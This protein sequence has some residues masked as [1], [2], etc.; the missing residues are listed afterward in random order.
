M[1]N[2]KRR[3]LFKLAGAGSVVAAAGVML[4]VVGQLAS[5]DSDSFAFR[6]TLGLPESPLPSYATLVVEGTVNIASGVGLVTS[7]VLAGHPG[8]PSEIG[9]PGLTRVIRVTGVDRHAAQLSLRGII[10]DRSQL[11]PGESPQVELVVDRERGVVR[12]PFVG[13]P[14]SLTLV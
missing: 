14:V 9:L 10:E 3:R 4:P 1:E 13:R 6:A 7:R 11:Q 5:Q 8:D 12:A 2:M